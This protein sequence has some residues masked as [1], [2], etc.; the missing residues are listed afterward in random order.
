[1]KPFERQSHP[2][3]LTA[4]IV[5]VALVV[6]ILASTSMRRADT[7]AHAANVTSVA[8]RPPLRRAKTTAAPSDRFG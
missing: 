5:S 1:M 4:A 3:T 7:A 6:L 2:I 8:T